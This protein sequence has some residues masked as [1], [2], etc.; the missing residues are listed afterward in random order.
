MALRASLDVALLR[1]ALFYWKGGE[2]GKEEGEGSVGRASWKG[3]REGA[4]GRE[5]RK[6]IREGDKGRENGKGVKEGG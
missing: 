4:T 6:G 2:E 5:Q 1:E 3:E